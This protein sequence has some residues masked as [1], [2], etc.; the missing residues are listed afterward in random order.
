[1][2]IT[3]I[4]RFS[5]HD[6][7]GI[8]TVAFLK[9]CTLKCRWC[10]NPETISKNK[11]VLFRESKC[12]GCM[13]CRKTCELN[14]LNKLN[15]LNGLI[16]LNNIPEIDADC[17]NCL[18]CA[19]VCPSGTIEV[20]G[21]EYT[22]EKLF[23]ELTRDREFYAESGGGVTFSGGEP[24][25]HI[26][27]ILPVIK[28]LAEENISIAFETAGNVKWEN[29]EAALKYTDEFLF[30]IKCIEGKL[31]KKGTGVSNQLILKNF[32]K[33]YDARKNII[34]RIPVI[35]E[36][37]ADENN[38][39]D[40]SLFLQDYPDIKYAEFMPFHSIASHKYH[41]MNL[42]N[43]YADYKS[44]GTDSDM[45]QKFRKLFKSHGVNVK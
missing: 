31:H 27:E 10:H 20:I 39:L 28:M 8:R 3:N 11:Q 24:I 22:P 30:D 14:N 23:L 9:G 40:I 43:E 34:V 18:K 26:F 4:Q 19:E 12:I 44:I 13:T 1:M 21:R 2:L 37:N 29:F 33:L 45:L 36:F 35:P 41:E 5:L 25:M 15:G 16:I 38:M 17:I 6:G 42:I 7:A 32:K